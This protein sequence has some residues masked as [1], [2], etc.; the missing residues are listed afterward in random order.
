MTLPIKFGIQLL[1]IMFRYILG[2]LMVFGC[3]L[4][5]VAQELR[6]QV[7][8]LHPTL[9]ISN[10]DLF[11]NMSK[12]IDNLLNNTVWTDEIYEIEEKINC[13]FILTL[14]SASGNNYS[15]TLQVNYNRPVFNSNYTSPVLNYID[16]NISFT[17]VENTPLEYV[18]NQYVS[19]F[20]S[21][22]SFYAYVILGFDKDTYSL[23]GGQA[24]FL[25]AQNIINLSQGGG[26][27]WKSFDGN[28]NRYWLID[29]LLNTGFNDIR[30]CA[31]NYHR[32][33]LD[34]MY[35]EKQQAQ[36]KKNIFNALIG[37][38]NVYNSRPNAYI[39]Q[40]FFDAKVNEIVNIFK[41][42]PNMD[43]GKLIT[44]LSQIDGGRTSK[45]QS[46]SKK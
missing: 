19:N 3:T 1:K 32:K 28:K 8:I 38:Q 43:T 34:L 13:S 23:N 27:G 36:A 35:D 30:K 12:A 18:E 17:Y 41:D 40:V 5:V 46:I 7:Q 24:Y 4:N 29:N 15:G 16:K 11:P 9:Q 33:G 22:F 14:N 20:A 39:L 37:L 25:Q 21:I 10:Q 2:V 44:V 45:Y 26:K 31:Y 42:G 6:A